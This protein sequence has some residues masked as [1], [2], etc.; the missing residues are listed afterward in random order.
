MKFPATLVLVSASLAACRE[1]A[2]PAVTVGPVTFRES[3]LVGLAAARRHTLADLTAFGLAVAD[4]STESLGAPL[5][6]RQENDRLLDIFAA[7]L[8]LGKNGVGDEVLEARYLTDPEYELT[9]RHILF[10]S[11][12]WRSPAERAAAKAKAERALELVKGGAD[13]AETAARLSEEPGAQGRQGLLTPGRKGAWVDEFWNAASALQVG[14]ISPVVETQYGYHV[15]RLEGREIVPFA[16]ARSR[17]AREVAEQIEDPRP[18]LRAWMDSVGRQVDVLDQGLAT[19]A[20]AAAEPATTLAT[21]VGGSLTLAQYEAFAATQPE[22]W[23]SGGRGLDPERFRAS[24]GELARRHVAL[25]EA[26]RRS[27]HV[28]ASERAAMDRAWGDT[29]YQWSASMGFSH[30]MTP[31]QVAVAAVRALGDPGQ[32]AGLTRGA[33]EGRAP[34]LRARYP[35]HVVGETD[36]GSPP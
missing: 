21:W 27:L 2:P 7:E 18:V 28:P 16:E 14:E 25:D 26:A 3:Q 17:V 32:G 31:A 34:L 1:A 22:G 9:V 5:L 8:T 23:R 33:I 12:R 29:V 30:G 20:S 19:A 36:D 10:L 13:F 6:K 35:M 4:S 11:E 24:V 15:L